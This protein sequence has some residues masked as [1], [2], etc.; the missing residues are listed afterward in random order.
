EMQSMDWQTM[1]ARLV[2]KDEPSRGGWNVHVVVSGL[3]DAADPIANVG[4]NA[5]CDKAPAGVGWP[6]DDEL[7]RLR[8]TYA[9]AETDAARKA[10]AEQVQVRATQV[11]TYVPLGELRYPAAV[12]GNVKGLLSGYFLTAWNVEVE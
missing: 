10:I 2:R 5:A 11:G 3:F 4:L 7:E 9:R 6:C 8:D 1:V 12:R